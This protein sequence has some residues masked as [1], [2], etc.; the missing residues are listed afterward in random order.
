MNI[1]KTNTITFLITILTACS[2]LIVINFYTIKTLL[3]TR[4]YVNA[5]SHYSK[6]HNIA[7]RNLNNYLLTSKKEYW[8]KFK[9]NISIPMGDTKARIALINKLD[10]ET[11][12]QGFREGKNAE[13][14]LKNMIW[15]FKNFKKIT[16]L[17]KA[18]IE[19]EAADG[20]IQKLYQTG[21]DINQ[22]INNKKLDF[23]TKIELL[24][25]LDDISNKISIRQNNFSK[26]L[27]DG[28]RKI[29]YYL[30]LANIFLISIIITSISNYYSS[31]LQKKIKAKQELNQQKEQLEAI[32]KD[33][34]KTKQELHTEI[35][36][37]KK[38]IGTISHDIRSPLKYIQLI[39]KHLSGITKKDKNTSSYK[40]AISI[41]K[42]SSQLYEF[43]KTLIE[44]S[45]I[46]IEDRDYDQKTYSVHD[47][48][49]SK[50][51]FFE[52]IAANN[53]T[54]IKNTCNPNLKSNINIRIISIIIH[55]L[56]DNA[57]KNTNSGIIEI[58]SQIENE[59]LSYWVKDTGSG[60]SPDIID[61]YT[62]LFKN[63]DPEKLILSTYGIGLHLVL[64]LLI[65]LN[66]N[67]SFSSPDNKGTMVTIEIDLN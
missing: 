33:L 63:R 12:K 62:K 58:G 36:Q 44:Y 13:E 8:L 17:K 37:H 49:E 59:K 32:I 66:G 53:N 61:Y 21:I 10:N 7:I 56:I 41:Y 22:K 24:N 55:N 6:G 45:K 20:L 15:L 14:D 34:E 31:M 25:Q 51:T 19:W 35:I 18:I 11:I 3:A 9:E 50:K 64:E 1:A 65:I 30:L 29:N 48:I 47:L 57:V 5:E 46:Y 16:F 42:S 60:M 67:I 43:T 27:G 28:T 26:L 38:I 54:Q 2:I 23:Q 52:E 39:A 40:Y 4:A